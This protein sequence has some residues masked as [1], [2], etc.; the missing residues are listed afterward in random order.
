MAIPEA[1]PAGPE[2]AGHVAGCTGRQAV[3]PEVRN[4]INATLQAGRTGV[5]LVAVAPARYL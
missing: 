3:D 1:K 2:Q 4:V 5:M